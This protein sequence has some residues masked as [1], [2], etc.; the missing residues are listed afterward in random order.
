MDI[1]AKPEEEGTPKTRVLCEAEVKPGATANPT[2]ARTTT[3][4]TAIRK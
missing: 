1:K 4:A 2:E 3:A